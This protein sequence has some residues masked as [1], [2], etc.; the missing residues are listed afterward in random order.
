MAKL[1]FEGAEV[2]AIVRHAAEAG[3]WE[4]FYYETHDFDDKPIPD[5][6]KP[7]PALIFVHDEG[8]YLMS[9]GKPRQMAN[10]DK[11]VVVY[12][13]GYDPGKDRMAVWEKARAAV[14]GDDFAEHLDLSPEFIKAILHPS[15]RALVLRVSPKSISMTVESAKR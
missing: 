13:K 6:P 12:A 2:V 3:D 5:A 7:R 1:T 15:F 10:E 8:L 9:N 4:Q 11:R 14:G